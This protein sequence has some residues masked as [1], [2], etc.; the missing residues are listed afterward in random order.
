MERSAA[1]L[2]TTAEPIFGDSGHMIGM[3]TRII[4]FDHSA[5]LALADSMNAPL[6]LL[7][8]ILPGV[9]A[10]LIS[11]PKGDDEPDDPPEWK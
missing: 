1:Q 2:R 10:A 5:V 7:L 11:G 9:E 4:G 6:D 3:R 8:E